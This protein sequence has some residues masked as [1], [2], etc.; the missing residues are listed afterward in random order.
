MLMRKGILGGCENLSLEFYPR[1]EGTGL[2]ENS[3]MYLL[4]ISFKRIYLNDFI[5]KNQP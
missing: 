1:V 2:H 3:I 5:L 4:V